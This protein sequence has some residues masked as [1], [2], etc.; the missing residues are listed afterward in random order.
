MAL[1]Y[2]MSCSYCKWYSVFKYKD[3]DMPDY[4]QPANLAGVPAAAI[5]VKLSS[6]S[7]PLAM[8]V[9]GPFG[10]DMKVLGFCKWLE[11]IVHF[12]QPELI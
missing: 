10:Q 4:S 3:M 5:P 8:Q 2:F 6:R 9:I 12:P 7:L 1:D 11:N